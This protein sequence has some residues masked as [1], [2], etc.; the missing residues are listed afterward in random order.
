MVWSE[1]N[2]KCY[3]RRLTFRSYANVKADWTKSRKFITCTDSFES[4][5]HFFSNTKHDNRL[6]FRTMVTFISF[7]V[8]LEV[9][10]SLTFE[11]NNLFWQC[12]SSLCLAL[13]GFVKNSNSFSST[14]FSP[15]VEVFQLSW[16]YQAK[17]VVLVKHVKQ[18]SVILG[19]GQIS[20]YNRSPET[21]FLTSL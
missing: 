15:L 21:S 7:Q 20:A 17:K 1:R 10:Y 6:F 8:M 2:P 13:S 18:I 4:C 19:K 16:S 11:R 3:R 12:D 9:L 14:E 5:S